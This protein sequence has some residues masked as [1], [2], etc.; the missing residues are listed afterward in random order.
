MAD[1]PLTSELFPR[2]PFEEAECNELGERIASRYRELEELF[3]H[4]ASSPKRLKTMPRMPM[5]PLAVPYE[6]GAI[7]CLR[8]LHLSTGAAR[9]IGESNWAAT[10]PV[11]RALFE[12]WISL[13][14]AERSF[15]RLA[16]DK[17]QWG[18]YQEIA[19]RLLRGRTAAGLDEGEQPD[20]DARIIPI[21]QMLDLVTNEIAEGSEDAARAIRHHYSEL[22]DYTHPT[23]WSL[24]FNIKARPDGLG[25]VI[26]RAPKSQGTL[27]PL[28]DLDLLL[29]VTL[30][31]LTRLEKTA[32]EVEDAFRHGP[33]QDPAA[34]EATRTFLEALAA[35]NPSLP[36]GESEVFAE[37]L[38]SL[39]E[40]FRSRA[41][42]VAG[43]S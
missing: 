21:G 19:S 8:A 2:W 13:E 42:E 33:G 7:Q 12:V 3:D 32:D 4:L 26:D 23:I 18:R 41:D 20:E 30:E 25:T 40:H 14:Y 5:P 16:L 38:E 6:L 27:G 10:F 9:L 43:D 31:V 29:S 34:E 11:L 28:S 39:L 15:R 37:R 24:T 17:S 35:S 36:E 1:V 22:S